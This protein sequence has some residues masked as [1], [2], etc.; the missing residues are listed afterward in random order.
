M[1][2]RGERITS[3]DP[4]R[5]EAQRLVAAALAAASVAANGLTSAHL[6]TGSAECCV[7]PICRVIAAMRDPSPEFAERLSEGAADLAVGVASM[8]RSLSGAA[9]HAAG[10]SNG[11]EPGESDGGPA[12]DPWHQ[13]TAAPDAATP[14]AGSAAPP[15]RAPMARKAV[16]KAAPPRATAMAPATG[17]DEGDEG[18]EADT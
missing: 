15:P 11:P 2:G 10:N 6:S 4:I 7:C 3:E 13:A 17:Q 1:S 8:L 5:D 16:K 14:T 12:D 9:H 18:T